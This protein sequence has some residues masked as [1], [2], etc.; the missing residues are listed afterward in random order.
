M[1]CGNYCG[2]ELRLHEI[3]GSSGIGDEQWWVPPLLEDECSLEIIV[4]HVGGTG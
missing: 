4:I 2:N 3:V 1:V